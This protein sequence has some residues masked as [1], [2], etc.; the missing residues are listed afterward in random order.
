MLFYSHVA[1]P[2]FG[3]HRGAKIKKNAQ[4]RLISVF[5]LIRGNF[6]VG[7]EPAT[8]GKMPPC[9]G[10]ATAFSPKGPIIIIII[11]ISSSSS[12]SIIVVIVLLLLFLLLLV[13][14]LLLLLLLLLFIVLFSKQKLKLCHHI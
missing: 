8:G 12:S 6:E 9:P 14:L 4:M 7:A 5:L 11:I 2:Y 13:L 1:A 10:A 3:G